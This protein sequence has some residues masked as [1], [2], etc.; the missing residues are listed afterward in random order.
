MKSVIGW[1]AIFL[2]IVSLAPS[3]VPGAVSLIGLSASF[4]A[5]IMSIFSVSGDKKYHFYITLAIVVLGIFVVNDTLRL[6]KPL[7]I[8]IITK[9]TMY[10][11]CSLV[12][13]GCTF[14]ATKLSHY[15]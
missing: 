15:E 8:P 12:V 7:P 10:A 5:L 4:G 11:I 9:I 2:A 3:F 1:V 14:F 6:W 13:M